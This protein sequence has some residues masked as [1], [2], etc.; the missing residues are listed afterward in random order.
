MN[1]ALFNVKITMQKSVTAV[2]E[3]GN[4]TNEW[5]DFHTCFATVSG[6]GGSEKNSVG[7]AWEEN[8]IS[9][10][11]RYCKALDELSS[12]KHRVIFKGSVYNIVSVDHL[13]Y[14]RKCLKIRCKRERESY[15]GADSN[16]EFVR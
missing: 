13:N 12:A 15:V 6:E 8:D 3:I 2:D 9:F 11:V 10:T 14:K 16:T 7:G 5:S 1:I 4:H